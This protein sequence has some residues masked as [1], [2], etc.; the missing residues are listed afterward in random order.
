[1]CALFGGPRQSDGQ[2]LLHQGDFVHSLRLTVLLNRH[3][4]KNAKSPM[5]SIFLSRNV[6]DDF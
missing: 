1:L 2:R 5:V 6:T 3:N 4:A